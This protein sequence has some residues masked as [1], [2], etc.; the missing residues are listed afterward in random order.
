MMM[1]A[2]TK[3][4]C[5]CCGEYFD[6]S[7]D[8]RHPTCPA[9]RQKYGDATRPNVASA[10]VMLVVGSYTLL[11]SLT[12]DWLSIGIN[13]GFGWR[14]WMGL[15]LAFVLVISGA[16]TRVTAILVMG[17]LI[18]GVTILAD[19]LKLGDSSG[20]GWQ[21]IAGA[22]IGLIMIGLGVVRGRRRRLDPQS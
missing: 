12:A 16:L 4:A 8:A 21:Q 18:G 5:N 14:Q 1:S 2:D 22:V 20:F 6:E 19:V 3:R 11:L 13:V 7:T 9:C 17:L 10:A 15:L